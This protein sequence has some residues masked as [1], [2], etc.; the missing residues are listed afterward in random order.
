MNVP[1]GIGQHEQFNTEAQDAY[2]E[3]KYEGTKKRDAEWLAAVDD[4]IDEANK[5]LYVDPVEDLT[6][7]KS[8]IYATQISVLQEL[9]A[10]MKEV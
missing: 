3:G 1:N 10:R 8:I 5:I 6:E 2:G 9:K 4:I 7:E